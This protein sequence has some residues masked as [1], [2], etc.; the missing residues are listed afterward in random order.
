MTIL[1]LQS[2][3]SKA[4]TL[5][6][7]FTIRLREVSALERVHVNW[8]PNIKTE[9]SALFSVQCSHDEP[10]VSLIYIPYEIQHISYTHGT[11]VNQP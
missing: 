2:T 6:T 1:N 5:G 10:A 11:F 4:D 8:Y 7:R 9:T 3:L